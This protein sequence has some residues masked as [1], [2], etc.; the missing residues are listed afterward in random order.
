M[1][2]SGKHTEIRTGPLILAEVCFIYGRCCDHEGSPATVMTF[3][4]F[5]AGILVL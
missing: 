3:E 5:Q 1:C 2:F 4:H